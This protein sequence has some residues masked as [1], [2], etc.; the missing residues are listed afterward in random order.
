M[1]SDPAA[2]APSELL[3]A[4]VNE[5][6]AMV[7]YW[8]ATLRCRF[9]NRA[10]ERWFGVSPSSL[11]GTHIQELLGPLYPLNLPYIQ[12]ALRGE[13]QE[14]ERAIP[15][16]AGGPARHSL[17]QYVPDV[18]DGVVV[19]FFVLV[20]DVSAIKRT[21]LR[22]RESEERFRL[23][24]DEAPIGM[25]VVSLEGRFVRVNRALCEILGYAA[26]E[27][28]ELDVD[29]ITHPED[30]AVDIALAGQLSRREISR[31]Q[32]AKRCVRKDGPTVDVMFS[33]SEVRDPD[34]VPLSFVVQIEDV[35]ERRRLEDKLR[36]AEA[37]SSGIVAISADAII[38]V[39][40]D[41]RITMFNEGAEKIFGYSKAEAI[42]EPLDLL[43]PERLRAVHRQHVGSFAGGPRAARQMGERREILGLRKNGEEFPAAAAISKLDVGGRPVLT[44]AL[45]DITEQRRIEHEQ[46]F[47]AEVGPVLATSLDFEET[48]TR[49]ARLAVQDFADLCVVD[50][51]SDDKVRKLTVASH[52]P[53]KAWIC[54]LLGEVRLDPARP[55]LLRS[56]LETR[57]PLL[58]R[59]PSAE[60]IASFA[61]N[62]E[63][64]RALQAAEIRSLVAVPLV[65]QNRLV[66]AIG[67]VSSTAS[68]LY[69]PAE[70]RV[71]EELARRA[72][73]SIENARLYRTARHAIQVRDDVLGIVAHDLRNPLN[74]I[75][76]QVG[77]L[78]RRAAEADVRSGPTDPRSLRPLEAIERAATRMNRLIQDLLDVTRMEAGRLSVELAPVGPRQV[79]ADCVEAQL[80]LARGAAVELHVD[81][82]PSLPDVVGDRDRL[83][84]VFEN[85]IGNAIKFTRPG[86]RVTIGAAPTEH[87]VLFW[88]ADTGTGIDAD[89]VPHVFDRFWQARK[90]DRKGAGLGLPIVKGVVE[91]HSGRVW[92]ESAPDRGSTFFFTIPT[93]APAQHQP[94]V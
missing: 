23:T 12:G 33:R 43:I 89:A 78:Q 87:E 57:G 70:L 26:D 1:P 90:G 40:E 80:G 5:I 14:F 44:V 86:G 82:A 24:L 91:A 73:L 15:D 19:G 50:V 34:G 32:V 79:I 81:V 63:H 76:M 42:G 56:V 54:E 13:R 71:A 8:D 2:R 94:S 35:T 27:L 92:V 69:G 39:D 17:A 28:T 62:E 68:R 83:L 48:L 18:V 67:F 72:A 46:H 31:Y 49:I 66:G 16:P 30:R 65:A 75:L 64:L 38:S 37:R 51:V 45:R 61:Q 60:V 10:Y 41:Q 21:E 20:T 74:S 85:L 25:A 6:S 88:V 59:N 52:D 22:L 93:A 84:Q 47:L 4:F 58:L 29:A 7:A 11:L 77:V 55:H 53:A 9:A 36:L 3:A